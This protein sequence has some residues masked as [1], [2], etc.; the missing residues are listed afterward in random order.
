MPG[1]NSSPNGDKSL[2]ASRDSKKRLELAKT[3]KLVTGKTAQQK[4]R[5]S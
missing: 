5:K 1:P 2:V 3:G 4:Q